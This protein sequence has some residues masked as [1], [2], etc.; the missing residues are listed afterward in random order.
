[1]TDTQISAQADNVGM[2]DQ[3]RDELI[4]LMGRAEQAYDQA[5]RIDTIILGERAWDLSAVREAE[6]TTCDWVN[7]LLAAR[8]TLIREQ[9]ARIAALEA[10]QITP[11]MIKAFRRIT[12]SKERNFYLVLFLGRF[13]KW[14]DSLEKGE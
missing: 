4:I 10:R 6:E 7:D 14:I 13:E 9:A 11:E 8:D 1:M 12:E 5:P 3:E 2:T